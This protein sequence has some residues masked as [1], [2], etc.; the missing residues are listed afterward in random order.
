MVHYVTYSKSY[1][2]GRYHGTVVGAI[3]GGVK[4]RRRHGNYRDT[5]VVLAAVLL[6][7]QWRL[8]IYTYIDQT[9][10]MLFTHETFV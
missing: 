3:G 8:I 5:A 1:Y 6:Y 7:R 9:G 4:M 10:E 2:T